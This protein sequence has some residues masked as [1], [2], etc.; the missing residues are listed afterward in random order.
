MTPQ[1]A[2]AVAALLVMLV[3][4]SRFI[5]GIG[6]RISG[7]NNSFKH[8][9]FGE[10]TV[11]IVNKDALDRIPMREQIRSGYYEMSPKIVPH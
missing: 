1:H 2:I 7:L 8:Y 4:W 11:A 6:A 9:D 3:L 5:Y 10:F